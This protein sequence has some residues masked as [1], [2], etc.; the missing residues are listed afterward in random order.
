[1]KIQTVYNVVTTEKLQESVDF[2]TELFGFEVVAD[3]GWYKHLKHVE[4]GSELAFMEPDHPTQPPMFQPG[5]SGKGLILSIQVEDV[6]SVYEKIKNSGNVIDFELT[7]EEW[8]QT[9][10]GIHDPNGI[11]VDIVQ[12]S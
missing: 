2:Y 10:F 6:K 7:T 8:G 3:T 12:H 1:M 11:A 9:H 4:S 5:W